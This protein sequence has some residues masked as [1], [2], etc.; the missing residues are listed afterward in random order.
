MLVKIKKNHVIEYQSPLTDYMN[1]AISGRLGYA[2]GAT[3]SRTWYNR[4]LDLM[5]EVNVYGSMA[6]SST[7]FDIGTDNKQY[8]IF[9]L[10]PNLI[11]TDSNGIRHWYWLKAVATSTRF[12]VASYDGTVD[13]M[14][15]NQNTIGVRPRFLID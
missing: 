15:A 10:K 13:I 5:S 2:A 1:S 12:V 6:W 4:K 14:E 8:A 11:S 7:G 9:Q 3:V